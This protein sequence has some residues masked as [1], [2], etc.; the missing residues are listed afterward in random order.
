MKTPSK[1]RRNKSAK[2]EFNLWS[3]DSLDEAL[4]QLPMPEALGN[5]VTARKQKKKLGVFDDGAADGDTVVEQE[6]QLTTVSAVFSQS[7][8]GVEDAAS[9]PSEVDEPDHLPTTPFD[10]NLKSEIS[11]LRSKFS[12]NASK[13]VTTAK[14]TPT[15]TPKQTPQGLPSSKLGGKKTTTKPVSQLDSADAIPQTSNTEA[16][17]IV[18]PGSDAIEPPSPVHSANEETNQTSLP[19][20]GGGS[21]DLLVSESEAEPSEPGTPRA[22]TFASLDLG[23]FAFGAV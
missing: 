2:T 22:N 13:A 19:H 7:K 1:Q 15:Q 5:V 10:A 17:D 14:A 16:E 6:T 21:E 20:C 18:I 3:D 23:R 9:P 12:F 8:D 4:S 11:D